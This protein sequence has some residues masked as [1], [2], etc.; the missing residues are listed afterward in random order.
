M[1]I[2]VKLEIFK[3]SVLFEPA[4]AVSLLLIVSKALYFPF[5]KH[6]IHLPTSVGNA[7]CAFSIQITAE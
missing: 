2:S 6:F 7:H 5:C 4:P 1:M 3:V